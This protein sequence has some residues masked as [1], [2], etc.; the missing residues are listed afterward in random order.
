MVGIA[1]LGLSDVY[2]SFVAAMPTLRYNYFNISIE[3]NFMSEY[4]RIYTPGGTVFLTLVTY[5]RKPLF[6]DP[7]NISKL[8]LAIAKVRQRKPFEITGAVILPDHIHFLW[9]LPI[10]DIAY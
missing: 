3:N 7:E 4:R 10:N 6:S 1:E 9:T 2:Q 8:R 5:Q